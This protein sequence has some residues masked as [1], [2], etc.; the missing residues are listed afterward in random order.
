MRIGTKEF[1]AEGKTYVMGILNVT[2]DSFSDGGRWNRLDAALRHVEEMLAQGMD[3][4]D[5]GGESTRP[6][7]TLLSEQEEM[8][9]VL[10]VIEAVKARFDVP[11]SLDTCK[12]AVAAAG[13]A[14]GADLINDIWGLKYDPKMAEVI[15][16]ADVPCCLMHNRKEASYG[17]FF[18]DMLEDL[19]GTLR[20]A[21]Q[22]GISRG[23]IILDPGVGFGKSYRNNLECIRR[24]PELRR[25]FDL[26]V[27]LGASRKSVIGLTLD[28]P[29]DDR[30]EGTLATTVMAAMA[31]CMFVR[32]HDVQANVR[33]V[34]MTEAVC[35]G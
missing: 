19:K 31:G 7:Y 33:A 8:D 24:L 32:V 4:V 9:R 18:V 23:K 27:L 10:P 26:P 25:A 21:E 28:L 16:G 30:L 20:L 14:A 6:G 22:A 12:S 17:L 35:Y 15:A 29:A 2:P 13:L 34:R 11:V 1:Q 5:I 3:V